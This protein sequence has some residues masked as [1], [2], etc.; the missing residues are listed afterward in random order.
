MR[1][2]MIAIV[3]ALIWAAATGAFD[4]ANL[5]RGF[6]VGILVLALVGGGRKGAPNLGRIRSL[7]GLALLFIGNLTASAF[8]CAILAIRP[9]AS[10]RPGLLTYRLKAQR[11]IEINMLAVLVAFAPGILAVELSSDRRVMMVHAFRATDADRLAERI[12]DRFERRIMEAF[13]EAPGEALGEAPGET[14]G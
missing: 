6:V 3:L 7:L 5:V 14:T 11:D 1:T 12:G 13:G 4:L 10:V 9:Q 8:H 2:V